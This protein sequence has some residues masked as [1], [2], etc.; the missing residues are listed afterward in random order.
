MNK[1]V[2]VILVLTGIAIGTFLIQP[3]NAQTRRIEI[4]FFNNYCFATYGES[5]TYIR[6]GK[7]SADCGIGKL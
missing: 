2:A 4:R 6:V 3:I 5:I 7:N 1:I